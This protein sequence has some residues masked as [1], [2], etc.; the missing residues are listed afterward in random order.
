MTPWPGTK[1][2]NAIGPRV[3]AARDACRRLLYS[4]HFADKSIAIGMLLV[5]Y[6]TQQF[7][8]ANTSRLGTPLLERLWGMS[9]L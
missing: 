2:D 4:K 7:S 3:L 6:M 5:L 1:S 9:L 8:G